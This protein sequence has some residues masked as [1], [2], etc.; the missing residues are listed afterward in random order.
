MELKKVEN[1]KFADETINL[2]VGES[3]RLEPKI[4]PENVTFKKFIWESSNPDIITIDERGYI[5]AARP[6]EST[7][8]A[9][10]IRNKEVYAKCTIIVEGNSIGVK[11]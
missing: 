10:S 4:Q 11:T 1:I 7:I 3:L 5:F 6:G 2:L 8:T 9:T